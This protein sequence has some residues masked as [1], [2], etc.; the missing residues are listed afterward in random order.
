MRN[1]KNPARSYLHQA[2]PHV[3][4]LSHQDRFELDPAWTHARAIMASAFNITAGADV[5]GVQADLSPHAALIST[6][7]TG[8]P[9]RWARWLT[10]A[11]ILGPMSTEPMIEVAADEIRILSDQLR[12]NPPDDL[13]RVGAVNGVLIA[14]WTCGGTTNKVG[15]SVTENLS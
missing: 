5:I 12:A 15:P 9:R 6:Q 8:H 2:Y 3:C 11:T 10:Q 13:V 1:A 14:E 4:D 7:T